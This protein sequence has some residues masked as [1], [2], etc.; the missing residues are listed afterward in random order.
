M[1]FRKPCFLENLVSGGLPVLTY[2]S[3][4]VELNTKP[5]LDIVSEYIF[6]SVKSQIFTYLIISLLS[7][8]IDLNS[9][10]LSSRI[11]SSN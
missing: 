11:S 3:F 9:Q 4:Y 7:K 5:C 2:S 10:L 1:L 6:E 8:V